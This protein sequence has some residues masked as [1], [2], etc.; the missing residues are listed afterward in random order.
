MATVVETLSP[1]EPVEV[2]PTG[3]SRV[4]PLSTGNVVQGFDR[5]IQNYIEAQPLLDERR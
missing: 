4:L 3:T 5:E 2:V 1:Q